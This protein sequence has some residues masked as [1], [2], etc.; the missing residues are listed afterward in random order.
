[1]A[2]L[3]LLGAHHRNRRRRGAG[4][5]PAGDVLERDF[6]ADAS[7][8]RQVA[9]IIEFAGPSGKPFL[10]GVL[11]LHDR[12]IAD[13]AIGERQTTDLYVNALVMRPRVALSTPR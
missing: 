8:L 12:G 6:T 2:E 7:D 13:W 1:M 3:G 11:G 4:T 5:A 9:D 10:A